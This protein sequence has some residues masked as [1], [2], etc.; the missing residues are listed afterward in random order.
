MAYC[1]G[2]ISGH[3][4]FAGNKAGFYGGAISVVHSSLIIQSE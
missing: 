1:E 3:V 2:L 4:E